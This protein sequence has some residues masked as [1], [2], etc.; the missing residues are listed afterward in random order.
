MEGKFCSRSWQDHGHQPLAVGK[1]LV[2]VQCGAFATTHPVNLLNTCRRRPKLPAE[3][4]ALLNGYDP[5][6]KTY[7]ATLV[8][9]LHAIDFHCL[10]IYCRSLSATFACSCASGSTFQILLVA[11]IAFLFPPFPTISQRPNAKTNARR[12]FK[13]LCRPVAR[14]VRQRRGEATSTL[15][16]EQSAA[17]LL[18]TRLAT[19]FVPG[20]CV[21]RTFKLFQCTRMPAGE[22]N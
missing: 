15:E 3:A 2:C 1:L 12:Q 4:K 22:D 5:C 8:L 13:Q 7:I 11:L 9:F 16:T 20:R 18:H 19:P 10:W 14:T 21:A 6:L 17:T